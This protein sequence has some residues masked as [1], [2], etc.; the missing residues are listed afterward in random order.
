MSTFLNKSPVFGP[1]T[2]RR[3]GVSLGVNL[4][5][6]TGKICTFDCLYCENGLDAQRRTHDGYTGLGQVTDALER[7]LA[8]MA[9]RGEH[10]D[11][12]CFAGNGEPTA[13]PTFPQ[14]V[15][16]AL[17]L[18]DRYAP[19]AHVTVLSSGTQAG[20]PAVHAALMRVDRNVLKLDTVDPAYVAALDRPKVPYDVERQIETLASFSGHVI[21][22]TIFLRGSYEGRSFDNTDEGHVGAWLSALVRIQPRGV[23]IYTV[24][25]DTPAAGLTKAPRDAL[26]TIARRV[27]ELGFP[28]AVGY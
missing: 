26:D 3:F 21:V 14:A 28:C 19:D 5:P 7:T 8:D 23:T 9:E 4:M 12:I 2:S 24:D 16:V 22:Q 15:D 17:A 11:D 18:R 27:R 1:V 20:R 13:S 10:L 6:A 25:R